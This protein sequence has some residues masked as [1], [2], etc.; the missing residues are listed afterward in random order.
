MLHK[1]GYQVLEY[2]YI[3]LQSIF[4]LCNQLNK[5]KIEINM[6]KVNSHKGN[7]G[8]QMADQLAKSAANLANMCKYGESNFIKYN[9][10]H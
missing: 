3:L 4:E 6:I 5:H 10:K 1:D 7:Y 8:N 9:L 2:I